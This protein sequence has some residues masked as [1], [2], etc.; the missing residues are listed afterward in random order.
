VKTEEERFGET[1]TQGLTMLEDIMERMKQAGEHKISGNELFRLYDT[2]GFPVELSEEIAVSEGFELDRDGFEQAMEKQRQRARAAFTGYDAADELQPY[3]D[4]VQELP[5]TRFLGYVQLKTD[6]KIMAILKQGARAES[7]GAGTDAEVVLDATPFYAEAGGQIGDKG[8][9]EAEGMKTAVSDT[10]EPV[11]GLTVHR[12]HVENGELRVGQMVLARVDESRRRDTAAHHSATHLLQSALREVLGEHVHQSGSMVA[13]ERFRFDYPHFAALEK[14]E[15]RRIEALVNQRIREN[16]PVESETLSFDEAKRRGAIALF[17]EKYGDEVRMIKIG[18]VSKELCGGT[19][20]HS[21]GDIGLCV[22]VS[23]SSVA[24]GVRR[25]EAVC[26][27]T[28]YQRIRDNE[29]LIEETAAALNAVREDIPGRIAQLFEEKKKLE[30]ELTRLKSAATV[31]RTEDM[32]NQAVSVDGIKV[33]AV[34]LDDHDAT[35]LRTVADTLKAK[36]KSGVVVIG[37]VSNGKVLLIAGVT[38]DLVDRVHAGNLLKNVAKIVG[39]GGGGRADMA[40]AGG[41]ELEKL[42]V[43]LKEVPVMVERIMKAD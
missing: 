24:A 36:L 5:D 25:I 32:L 11:E 42:P 13:P 30:K 18:D 43:A 10:Q 4:L 9:L 7:V 28:A 16:I 15:L 19:H 40:Q 20:V 37:G 41:K 35:H 38:K 29:D 27:S 22:I 2:Y 39:G 34:R 12:V 21:T 33:L 17:G 3:I 6:A 1:L 23:E 26:G 14:R 8:T 31:D